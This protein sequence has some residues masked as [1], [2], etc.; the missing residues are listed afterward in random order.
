MTKQEENIKH[1][2]A[3]EKNRKKLN[4]NFFMI[5]WLLF[6]YKKSKERL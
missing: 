4:L 5:L 1:V 6:F 2:L 3:G